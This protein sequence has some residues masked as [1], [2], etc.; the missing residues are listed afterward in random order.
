MYFRMQKFLVAGMSK[1]GA[2]SAAFLLDR[3]AAVYMFDDVSDG[4]VQKTMA[5]LAQRGAKP[6]RAE[7][8]SSAVRECD[9]LVLS[10]GIPID[11][12]LPVAFRKAGKRILGEA[13]LGCLYLRAM[14]VAV[15]GTNGKTT[16][17]TMLDEIFRAAG[18]KSVACGNIGLPLTACVDGLDYGDVAVMEVSSFQLETLSDIRPH[19]A[20][21][22]NIA[23]DHLNRHYSMENYIFLKSKILRNMRESEFAVLNHDDAAVK[24]FAS[25]A[26]CPVRWFSI[27]ERVAGAYLYEGGLYFEN[28]KIMDAA[29]L[30]LKGEHNIKN[31]LAAICAAKLAGVES[32]VIASALS[33][34]R[35][36]RHRI[37]TVAEID[38]VTYIND[39]K[40]TNVDATLNAVACMQSDTVLLLGG[41]DKGYDYDE[42]FGKLRG[43]KVTHFVLYGENRFKLLNSAVRANESRITLC[44]DF[45]TAVRVAAMIAK[46]GQCV[47]LSPASSSF[48]AFSGYEER[49]ER[50]EC[51]VNGLKAPLAECAC[52]RGND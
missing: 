42:L 44:T 33:S 25:D 35:G 3:G 2:A 46:A 45:D 21:V 39:S 32:E 18:E 24:N 22:T 50:F 17:V 41:K 13:E 47:L 19:I 30:S 43:T 1:S 31:A 6:V 23:A 29:A 48:D 28:E 38:G 16:T 14:L 20:I 11:H 36:V 27:R 7:D 8:I 10:P 12:A 26:R 4:A 9:V 49:G 34:M 40:G 5:E 15:T 51:I 37:Q 52:A